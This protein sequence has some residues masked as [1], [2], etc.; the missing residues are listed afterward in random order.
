MTDV[1]TEPR[2][3]QEDQITIGRIRAVPQFNPEEKSRI[4]REYKC[5]LTADVQR[6]L[7]EGTSTKNIEKSEELTELLTEGDYSLVDFMFLTADAVFVS[8]VNSVRRVSRVAVVRGKFRLPRS[9]LTLLVATG[10]A[11]R[12]GVG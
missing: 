8:P 10:A 9:A 7:Q 4:I 11:V 2:V 6:S 1:N 12:P 5:R 3:G